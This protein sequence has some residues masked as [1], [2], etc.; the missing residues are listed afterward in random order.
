MNLPAP[1][2]TVLVVDDDQR[3]RLVLSEMISSLGYSVCTAVDGQEAL[4]KLEAD[5]FA[6]IV[7]DLVMPRM[8]GF[9][10]LRT[11]IERDEAIP[12]IVLTGFGNITHAVS[13]V[14]DLR[15]FWFLEKPTQPSVLAALLDRAIRYGSI[16]KEKDRLQ[17]ELSQQGVL[18]EMVGSSDA[19]QQVY[20][21]VQRVAP[22]HASVLITGESGTG[23]EVVARTIHKLSPRA[24]FPFVAVN[25]AALPQDLIE[26]EL[27]G[28]EKGAFT[29]AAGRH[30]GCFEQAHRGTLFLD[31]IGEM[32]AAMQARLLRALEESK[33][34]RLGGTSEI[35]VDVRVLAATNRRVEEEVAR[36]SLREDLYYRLNVFRIHLPPLRNHIEDLYELAT[37]MIGDLNRKHERKVTGCD[38]ATLEILTSYAWPGNVRELRNVLEFAVITAGE[39]AIMPHQLPQSVR[40]QSIQ[41]KPSSDDSEGVYFE[42]GRTLQEIEREYIVRTLRVTKDK[43]KTAELLGISLRTL[44]NRLA[45]APQTRTADAAR[46]E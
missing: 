13:V 31:E 36:K 43:K 35:P 33:V 6:V 19:M 45:A 8:D 40:S 17:R 28:H 25:C 39:G 4:S 24:A 12:A 44:Y 42:L 10:L 1:P 32:P 3:Q 34:R 15:A 2:S 38:A 7:T 16:L 37:A 20:T 27:F 26:S 41:F 5:H 30:A 18:G 29:G 22:A 46:A 23:K 9:Q 14:H 11:L 21:L